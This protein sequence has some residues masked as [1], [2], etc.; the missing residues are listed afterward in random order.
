MIKECIELVLTNKFYNGTEFIE[1][2]K[3]SKKEVKTFKDLKRKCFRIWQS[4]GK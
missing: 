2:S 4:R 1:F 3:G